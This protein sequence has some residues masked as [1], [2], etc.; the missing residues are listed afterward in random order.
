MIHTINNSTR[1]NLKN[2]LRND[3]PNLTDNE[4]NTMDDSVEKLI[5]SISLKIN[6]DEK[7]VAE[8]VKEKLE[9]IYSKSI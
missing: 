6:R 8:V 3:F 7:V 1:E 9:Y 2:E 5:S 4:L